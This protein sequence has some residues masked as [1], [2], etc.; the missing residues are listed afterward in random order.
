M[1]QDTEELYAEIGRSVSN[2]MFRKSR[3]VYVARGLKWYAENKRRLQDAVCSHPEIAKYA[4]DGEKNDEAN[5]IAAIADVI[6]ST[7][8]VV[9]VAVVA[10]LIVREGL[11]RFCNGN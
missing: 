4:K 9:P 11:D 7:L 2:D 8:G 1:E 3:Q 6:A 5:L 10:V